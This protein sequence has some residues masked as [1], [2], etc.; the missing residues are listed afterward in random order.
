MKREPLVVV[1]EDNHLLVIVKPAGLAT[2]G[3]AEGTPSAVTEAR[4]YLKQAYD[5][6]GNVYI[7]VV[8]RLDAVASGVLVL[9]RTSKAAAR[10]SEQFRESQ[11]EKLYWAAVGAAPD[12]PAGQLEHWV[13]KNERQR[14]M[15]VVR[16]H[17]PGAQRARLG[18]RTLQALQNGALLEVRLETGRKHQIRLQLAEIGCP[19]LGDKKYGSRQA[20]PAGIA[21]HAR[22]LVIEHPTRKSPLEFVAPLPAAWRKLGIRGDNG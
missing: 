19:I 2:M 10:L 1:Y 14:N 16:K 22:R 11:P 6:P 4:R 12:P 20:F 15:E 9:A 21:L 7:G 17:A 5:K 18:Y 3:V 13:L 8:S